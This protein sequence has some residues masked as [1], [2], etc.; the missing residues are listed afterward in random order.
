MDLMVQ[1]DLTLLSLSIKVSEL[2]FNS[3]PRFLI[4]TV[5]VSSAVSLFRSPTEGVSKSSASF[6]RT[7][8]RF[9]SLLPVLDS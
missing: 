1:M 2:E 7:V 3:W 5:S 8:L 9:H 4:L 6:L